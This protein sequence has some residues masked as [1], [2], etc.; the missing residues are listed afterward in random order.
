MKITEK[1]N[2]VIIRDVND[3][4]PTHTF[5]CGQCFR[6]D[7]ETDGSYTAVTRGATEITDL[8]V[9]KYYVRFAATAT[10]EA[11]ADALVEVAAESGYIQAADKERILKFR[12]NPSDESWIG[13]NK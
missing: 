6:W 9:G 10:T 13:G 11:S 1:N 12:N 3:F 7:E 4:N 8:P 5:M 2:S